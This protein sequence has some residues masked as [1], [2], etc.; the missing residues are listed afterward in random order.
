MNLLDYPRVYDALQPLAGQY[1]VNRRLRPAVA[2]ARG[3][4]VLD[5]GAGTGNLAH[6][7]PHGAV[8]WALDND[9][10]K[11]RRLA[12]KIPT[13]RCIEGSALNIDLPEEAV[14]WTVCVAVAHHVDDEDLPQLFA[15]L[16]RVTRRR[17]VFLDSLFTSRRGIA[18]LLWRYDRGSYP[19]S[20]ETLLSALGSHFDVERVERFRVLHEYVLC[21]GPP[22]RT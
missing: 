10:A 16:A 19:R 22:I 20:A 5:I 11:L 4:T 8:Y 2:S 13:A 17:L 9:P 3:Q 12:A 18:K 7:L 15:E 1:V 6:L 14:D 21:S